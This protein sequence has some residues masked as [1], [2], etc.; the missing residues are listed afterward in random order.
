MSTHTAAMSETRSAS[1][2]PSGFFR[3]LLGCVLFVLGIAGFFALIQRFQENLSR[4]LMSTF[5]VLAVGLAAG[6]APRASFYEWTGWFRFLVIMVVLPIGLIALGFFT[7][8]QIGLGPL[9][10]WLEGKIDSEQLMQFGIAFVVSAITLAAWRKPQLKVRQEARVSR[11]SPNRREV[12]RAPAPVRSSRNIRLRGHSTHS[13]QPARITNW[14]PRF[15]GFSKLRWGKKKGK[16][17]LVLSFDRRRSRPGFQRLFKRKPNV[18]LALVEV[19]RCP[20][21]LEEVKLSDPRGVKKCEVCN[22][23]H[24]ADCWEVAG[25]C[26][27]PHLNT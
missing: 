25:E 8:W 7:D 2:Q 17:K 27:V 9:E 18:N 20:F 12:D 13:S 5:A 6:S 15:K 1:S 24:H 22:T 14:F 11:Q 10:P 21:C 23:L 19:H 4:D 26:Q 16:E 3:K